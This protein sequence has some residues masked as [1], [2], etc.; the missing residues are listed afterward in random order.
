MLISFES[1]ITVLIGVIIGGI[2]KFFVNSGLIWRAE[3]KEVNKTK[4]MLEIE[5]SRIYKILLTNIDMCEFIQEENTK[6]HQTEGVT[7]SVDTFEVF[8]VYQNLTIDMV[9][10]HSLISTGSILKLSSNEVSNIQAI[11][12]EL[13]IYNSGADWFSDKLKAFDDDGIEWFLDKEP[14]TLDTDNMNKILDDIISKTRETIQCFESR[15]NF[16]WFDKDKMKIRVIDELKYITSDQNKNN[17]KC[18]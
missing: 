8:N 14:N 3:R 11:V 9:I 6:I 12:S 18:F 1:I 17:E 10:L 13:S 15:L 2:T 4:T 5:F 7:R 16:G